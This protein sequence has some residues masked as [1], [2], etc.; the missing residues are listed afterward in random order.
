MR[1]PPL[2]AV[3]CF[4]A[5]ARMNSFSKAAD[6]LNVTQS[7]VSHQVRLLEEYLGEDLFIRQGRRLSL[8]VTGEN[9]FTEVTHA[10]QGISQASR[11]IREGE[12]GRIRLS[13]YSSLAV[14]WLVPRLENLRQMHPEIDLTL[15]MVTEEPDFTDDVADCFITAYPPKKNYVSEFLYKELLYPFCSHRLWQQMQDQPLPD[16]LWQHP[17]LSVTSIFKRGEEGYDWKVWCQLGGFELPESIKMNHF[18]HMVLAAEAAKYH[19]GIAFL[20]DYF[21]TDQDRLQHLVRIPMHELPT[22]DNMYF[23]YKQSRARQPEII[24]LG[25]WL[26]QQCVD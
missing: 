26:K 20:N 17:L 1:L 9:Y 11:K 18:S 10:L 5:V 4:E 7:A 12:S 13:L 3:Q 2:R 22:G 14:K 19:Q 24:T 8:T 16:A 21:L 15:N 23:V 25:R 6:A